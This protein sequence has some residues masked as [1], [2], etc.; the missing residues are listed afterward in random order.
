MNAKRRRIMSRLT[1][2]IA[3]STALSILNVFAPLLRE[4]EQKE[5]FGEIYN[6]VITGIESLETQWQ[7]MQ[8]RLKPSRN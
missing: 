3:W 5:A 4:K 2:D 7:R 1:H 8:Q 6:R